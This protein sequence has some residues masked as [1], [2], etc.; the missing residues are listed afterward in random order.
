MPTGPDGPELTRRCWDTRGRQWDESCVLWE[1]GRRFAV[2]VDTGADDYRYPLDHL[3]G[4]WSVRPVAA[5][6]T[7]VTVRFELRPT[8]GAAG[9]AFAAA[10]TTGAKPLI[11]RIMS[12]WQQIVLADGGTRLSRRRSPLD[13]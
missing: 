5:D 6:Q 9:S 4:E 10:M 12:G 1:E 7:E 13:G 3:R 2:V 8:S 11:R